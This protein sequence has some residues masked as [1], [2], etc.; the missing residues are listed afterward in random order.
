MTNNTIYTVTVIDLYSD[1]ILGVRRTPVIYTK[2]R[3][4]ELSVKNNSNNLSDS[5]A[6]QYAVIEETMLNVIRP[7]IDYLK[8]FQWWYKYNS[9]TDEFEACAPPPQLVNQSGFG[10]G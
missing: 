1:K 8:P 6:Y 3:Y 7:S 4:A 10:I 2:F 5:G 9:V